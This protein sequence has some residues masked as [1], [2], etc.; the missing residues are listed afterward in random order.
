MIILSM[1]SENMKYNGIP[2]ESKGLD[3]AYDGLGE[4][5]SEG[6]VGC[7]VGAFVGCDVGA[8][9]GAADGAPV[10]DVAAVGFGV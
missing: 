1:L 2:S 3:G 5:Y 8:F 7:D 9:V 10:G 4:G 6:A